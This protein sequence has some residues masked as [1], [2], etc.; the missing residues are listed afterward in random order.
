MIINSLSCFFVVRN[1]I[2]FRANLFYCFE[3]LAFAAVML[4]FNESCASCYFEV[5]Y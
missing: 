2:V 3:N 4:D 5:V 1:S